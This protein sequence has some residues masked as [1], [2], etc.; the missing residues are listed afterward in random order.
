MGARLQPCWSR[1]LRPAASPHL[2]VPVADSLHKTCHQRALPRH[3]CDCGSRPLV[4][5]MLVPGSW[6]AA[7]LAQVPQHRAP[8]RQTRGAILLALGVGRFAVSRN[9]RPAGVHGALLLLRR[10]CL[11]LL[12]VGRLLVLVVWLLICV[13]CGVGGHETCLLSRCDEEV[14][15]CTL[16]LHVARR[17]ARTTCRRGVYSPRLPCLNLIRRARRAGASATSPA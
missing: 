16:L 11:A 4:A 5:A 15:V 12:L 3:R 2:R 10:D 17:G 7:I 13:R 9:S 8:H 1:V 6:S 14:P